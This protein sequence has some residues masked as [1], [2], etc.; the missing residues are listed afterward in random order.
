MQG[1]L[2]DEMKRKLERCRYLIT[3]ANRLSVKQMD[4]HTTTDK[5]LFTLTL[6]HKGQNANYEML[7]EDSPLHQIEY[8]VLGYMAA[9]K[10]ERKK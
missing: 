10:C 1:E 7:Q 5:K 4:L 8:F 6:C 9:I 2:S 3:K